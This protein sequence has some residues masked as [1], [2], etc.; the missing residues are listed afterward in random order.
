[1]DEATKF[2][3]SAPTK[4]NHRSLSGFSHPQSLFANSNSKLS[5]QIYPD[6]V[7]S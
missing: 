7:S 1:M 2:S 3:G 5:D 4:A 6:M